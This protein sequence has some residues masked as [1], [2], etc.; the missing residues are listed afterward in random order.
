MFRKPIPFL[1]EVL[2]LPLLALV[3]VTS[4][5]SANSPYNSTRVIALFDTFK[6]DAS[7]NFTHR[8]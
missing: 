3:I 1:V 2:S 7:D 6:R 8:L 5:R 4:M